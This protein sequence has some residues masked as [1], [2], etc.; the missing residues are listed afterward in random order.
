MVKTEV[1]CNKCGKKLDMWDVDAN[2]S[3]YRYLGYGSKYDGNEL[4]IDLC[5]ECMDKLIDSCKLPPV[6]V[7][8]DM[9]ESEIK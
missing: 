5:S 4:K 7:P 2:Y 1:Y 6:S 8:D 9:A 3:L